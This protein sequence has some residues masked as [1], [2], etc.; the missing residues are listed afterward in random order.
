VMA[1]MMMRVQSHCRRRNHLSKKKVS[2]CNYLGKLSF[3]FTKRLQLLLPFTVVSAITP[4]DL[5][6]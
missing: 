3:A 4:E 2:L 1:V 6:T 5:F